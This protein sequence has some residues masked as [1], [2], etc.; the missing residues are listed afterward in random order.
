MNKRYHYHL[1][2]LLLGALTGVG[3]VS[4]AQQQ[5]SDFLL[6]NKLASSSTASANTARLKDMKFTTLAGD[7]VQIVLTIDGKLSKPTSFTVD[8]PARIALDFPN[9]ISELNWR[10]R[11][12]GV[13]VLKS[14]AAIATNDKTRIVINLIKLVNYTTRF[15]KNQFIITLGAAKTANRSNSVGTNADKAAAIENIDFRRGSSG[16]GRVVVSLDSDDVIV[17]V[18]DETNKVVVDF[19]GTK[20]PKDLQQR[21]D[22]VDFATPVKMVDTF[23]DGNNVRMVLNIEGRYEHLAYQTDRTLTIDVKPIADVPEVEKRKESYKGE[24]LSLNFQ[25]IEIRAVLQLLADFTGLNIVVSDTVQGNITL[26]LKNTPWDQALDIILKT[27][28]LGMRQNDSVILIAPADELAARE[29]LELEARKQ[30]SE[31]APL[32]S[33][34]VQINYAKASKLAEIIKSDKNTLLSERG[35]VTVDE[36]TNSL[37][38]RDTADRLVEISK[39]IKSLDIPIR[40]VMIESRIVIASESFIRELGARLGISGSANVGPG[41]LTASGTRS[42]VS[43]ISRS[44]NDVG[45]V[46]GSNSGLNINLPVP[47]SSGLT[48]PS[49]ALGFLNSAG[50]LDLELSA[51]QSDGKGEVI[52][53]PRVITSNQHEAVI[54]QGEEI[55]YQEATSSGASSIAFRKAV[56][57]LKVTPQITP[58]DRIILDLNVTKDSRSTQDVVPGGVAIDTKEIKTQV[59]VNNGETVVLGGIYETQKHDSVDKIPL[60]GDIP[61]I[62]ALFRYKVKIESKEELLIFVTPKIIKENFKI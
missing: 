52:S 55:P 34:L 45:T 15:E 14:V 6:D 9:T 3:Q 46:I 36:R 5:G 35:N 10:S 59:L 11:R 54:E 39:L 17:D 1:T 25:D 2:I 47:S 26:R 50:L 21:L 33:D 24:R 30:I 22:V 7:R 48:A 51:L 27:K 44:G 29:K 42:G 56:M 41:T 16:E 12:V 32:R 60:L 13:G 57:S 4:A 58:D 19:L 28:G 53:N 23:M 20:L 38:I 61:F 18:R 8:D 40:Q 37:L 49:F 31:L 62:G 43:T